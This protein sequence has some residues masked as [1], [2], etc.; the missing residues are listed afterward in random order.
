MVVR[1]ASIGKC[2]PIITDFGNMYRV[3][4]VRI[5]DAQFPVMNEVVNASIISIPGVIETGFFKITTAFIGKQ[6]G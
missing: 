6:D 5:I 1:Q 4:N 3:D 2:G